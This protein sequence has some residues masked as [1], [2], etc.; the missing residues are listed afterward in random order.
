MRDEEEAEVG[1]LPLEVVEVEEH[2]AAEAARAAR[3]RVPAALDEGVVEVRRSDGEAQPRPLD[4]LQAAELGDRD[5]DPGVV[6][7][8][9]G[10]VDSVV[11]DEAGEVAA[12]DAG[13]GEESPVRARGLREDA[14][15][16][17]VEEP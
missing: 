5:V 13:V 14:A 10:A 6:E 15:G 7:P 4:R 1:A 16:D 9:D 17:R 8:L 12:L 11:R 2:L 3:A